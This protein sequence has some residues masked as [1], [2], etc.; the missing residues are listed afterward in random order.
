[1]GDISA[2]EDEKTTTATT[3]TT[4][5]T[6]KKQNNPPDVIIWTWDPEIEALAPLRADRDR[7]VQDAMRHRANLGS[8]WAS[9]KLFRYRSRVS[10][11]LLRSTNT[12]N[13][14]DRNAYNNRNGHGNGGYDEEDDDNE[15]E[16]EDEKEGRRDWHRLTD[17]ISPRLLSR[18]TGDP[19]VDVDGRV[20]WVV[21]TASTAGVDTDVIPG[22]GGSSGVSGHQEG[23]G[24]EQGQEEQKQEEGTGITTTGDIAEKE[25]TFL[26]IDLKKTWR[27]GAIGRERTEA[28]QDRSWALGDLIDRYS[29]KNNNNNNN[30][31]RTGERYILGELQFTFLMTLTMM[32]YSCLQQWKRLLSIILTSREAIRHRP[33]FMAA[34]LSL[35]LL[36]LQ[37]CDDVEG[38]LFDM[39]DGNGEYLRGLLMRFKQ[40]VMEVTGDGDGDGDGGDGAEIR[41]QLGRVEAWVG[42]QFGWDLERVAIVRRGLVQLEDGEEVELE[43]DGDEDEETGEYAPIVVDMGGEEQEQEDADMEDNSMEDMRY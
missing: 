12:N 3:A 27:E 24:K 10:S 22:L 31:D 25:F 20:R 9:G 21:T 42:E 26:P 15:N 43:V 37:R 18:V 41:A 33:R 39:E 14:M 17:C 1:M 13:R 11:S 4:T 19:E 23:Q 7:D 6:T 29:L 2:A 32:N 30:D 40:A 35:L 28:A 34:T 16:D 5:T 38:G 8:I 36:Q